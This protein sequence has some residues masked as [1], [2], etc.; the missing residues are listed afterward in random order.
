MHHD[1]WCPDQINMLHLNG[2]LLCVFDC[3]TTG[4]DP[5]KHDMWQFCCTPLDFNLM[6]ASLPFELLLKP[7]NPENRDT[8]AVSKKN[9]NKAILTGMDYEVAEGLFIEWIERL[10]LGFKKRIMPLAHNWPFDR[11]FIIEWLGQETFDFYIDPR[12][13]DTMVAGA[14]VNDVCDHTAERIP[15]TK[16]NLRHVANCLHID[17]DDGA[18]H[19]AIYDCVKTAEVYRKLI[20]N[21]SYLA[22]LG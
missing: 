20:K 16:L 19:D 8:S 4:L 1:T 10:N 7:R 14:F 3:E 22:E 18:A 5:L 12:Y 9:F 13:R 15:L 11:A 6:P 2:N 21:S 17:W